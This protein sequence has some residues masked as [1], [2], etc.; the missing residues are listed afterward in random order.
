[1]VLADDVESSWIRISQNAEIPCH[2]SAI[3]R[4][5]EPVSGLT[6]CIAALSIIFFSNLAGGNLALTGF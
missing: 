2:P 5:I 1:M 6:Y 3:L 4:D